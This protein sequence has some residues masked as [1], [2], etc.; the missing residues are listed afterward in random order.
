MNRRNGWIKEMLIASWL[1][2]SAPLHL[3]PA[4]R[5]GRNEKRQDA[6]MMWRLNDEHPRYALFMPLRFTSFNLRLLLPSTVRLSHHV[7]SSLRS[8]GHSLPHSL[9]RYARPDGMER[10]RMWSDM[11]RKERRERRTGSGKEAK[12]TGRFVG[13]SCHSL[14]TSLPSRRRQE[15]QGKGRRTDR[16]ENE[17]RA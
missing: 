4:P 2:T 6:S 1:I 8:L 3:H 13:S 14:I 5:G 9:P 17:R 11:T 10:N 15:R 7:G 12:W 16:G